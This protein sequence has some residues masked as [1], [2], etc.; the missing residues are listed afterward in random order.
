MNRK[1]FGYAAGLAGMSMFLYG[2]FFTDLNRVSKSDMV[3]ELQ[4]VTREVAAYNYENLDRLAELV[5]DSSN[6]ENLRLYSDAKNTEHRKG[7]LFSLAGL[8]G[9]IGGHALAKKKE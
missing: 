5:S 4:S 7:V 9:V 3:D 1:Y 8:A 2:L 6:V